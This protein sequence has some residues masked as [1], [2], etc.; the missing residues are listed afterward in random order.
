MP[1]SSSP[2]VLEAKPSR[3]HGLLLARIYRIVSA[4]GSQIRWVATPSLPNKSD[5]VKVL[6]PDPQVRVL[7]AGI[8]V[9][10]LPVRAPCLL[11]QSTSSSSL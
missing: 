2:D 7:V 1:A 3:C 11:L 8:R 9:P 5:N 4:R 6:I 10:S